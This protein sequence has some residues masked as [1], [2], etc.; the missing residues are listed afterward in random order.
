MCENKYECLSNWLN[1]YPVIYNWLH[2]NASKM[3][4]ENVSLNSVSGERKLEEYIDDSYKAEL[5]FALVLVKPFD[6]ETSETNM[7]AMLEIVNFMDW[8]DNKEN[9]DLLSFGSDVIVDKVDV[10]QSSPNMVIDTEQSL[11]KY[12]FQAKVTYIQNV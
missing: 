11:A 4:A 2:F 9:I 12:Q 8:V 6:F 7:Q 3:E 5:Y 10:L 1:N